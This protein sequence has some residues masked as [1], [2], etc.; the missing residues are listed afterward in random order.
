MDMPHNPREVDDKVE[1]VNNENIS[2]IKREDMVVDW[3]AIELHEL[4]HQEE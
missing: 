1:D 2:D 4:G 3:E